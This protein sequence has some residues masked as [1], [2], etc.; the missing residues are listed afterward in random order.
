MLSETTNDSPS[1]LVA[2]IILTC[3]RFQHG[4]HQ[5]GLYHDNQGNVVPK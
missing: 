5:P 1:D 4:K 3:R 2:M